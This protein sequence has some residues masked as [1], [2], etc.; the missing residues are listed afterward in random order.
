MIPMSLSPDVTELLV[1]PDLGAQSF[2][3]RRRTGEWQGGRMKVVSDETLSAIGIIQP[4]S[5]EELQYFPEGERRKGM[6]AIYTQTILHL[7]EGE[8]IADDVTWQGEAYKI[9]R[10][11]R[12]DDYGYCV[13]YAQKR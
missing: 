8:D 5:S 12:W 6:V 10:V 13:A 1:D 7:T 11:D 4:P 3:V 2:T 9:I